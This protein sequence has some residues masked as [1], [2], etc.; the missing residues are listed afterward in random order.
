M[1]EIRYRSIGVIHSEHT[2]AEKTPIQ[3]IY[4]GQCKGR[5]E[6]LPEFAEG[7]AD[8][9]A[10]SH[11]YLIYHLDRAGEPSMKVKPFLQD[12]ERGIFSTRFPRRPNP[13]GISIVRL[14]R[15]DGNVLELAGVDILDGTP[16]LDIKPYTTRFDCIQTDRNGWHE[17]VTED[18][19]QVRGK[20]NF[21]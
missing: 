9:D 12:V 15:V 14:L 2:E 8:L 5:V 4:A 10:F 18:D 19:A 16:L 20:R 7:L 11:I 1:M 21:S 13:I 17:E 6:V 3:P